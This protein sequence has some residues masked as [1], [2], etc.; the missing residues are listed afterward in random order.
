VKE[1]KTTIAKILDVIQ[2]IQDN[3][4]EIVNNIFKPD[5]EKQTRKE[6]EEREARDELFRRE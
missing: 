5:I 3:A 2:S 4:K 6:I 1:A